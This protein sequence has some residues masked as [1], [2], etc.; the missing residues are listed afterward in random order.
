MVFSYGETLRLITP[1]TGASRPIR[2]RTHLGAGVLS[3]FIRLAAYGTDT[4]HSQSLIV[5]GVIERIIIGRP[6]H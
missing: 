1:H 6:D 4:Y 5:Q 3:L 2:H